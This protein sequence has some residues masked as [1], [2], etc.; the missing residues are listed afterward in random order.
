MVS[1]FKFRNAEVNIG[2][3]MKMTTAEAMMMMMMMIY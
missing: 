1:P 3:R 2:Y